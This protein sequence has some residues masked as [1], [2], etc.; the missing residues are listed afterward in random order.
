MERGFRAA[1]IEHICKASGY[2]R[3]T[4]YAYFGSKEDILLSIVLKGLEVLR[5]DINA[6]LKQYGFFDRYFAIGRAMR[7]YHIN[8][9]QS[10][11]AI[12]LADTNAAAV[13]GSLEAA[14]LPQD[15]KQQTPAPHGLTVKIYRAG[16]EI[17]SLLG[18]FIEDGKASRHVLEQV[19][20]MPTVYIL[21]SSLSSLFYL[22]DSKGSFMGREFGGSIDEFIDYGL[23]QI[24]NSILVERI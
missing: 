16:E 12:N 10:F 4:L 1:T 13:A 6:A 11:Q 14:D 8:S 3:R 21:W 15:G 23:R 7:N 9:P 24:I 19:Q 17:N 22:A 20:V 2:S 18:S 5:D